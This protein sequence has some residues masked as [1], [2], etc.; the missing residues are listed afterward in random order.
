MAANCNVNIPIPNKKITSVLSADKLAQYSK[1]FS[2]L[3]GNTM[4]DLIEKNQG[5]RNITID[6]FTNNTV[7]DTIYSYTKDVLEAIL[8]ANENNYS[9][10]YME[11]LIIP[12]GYKN[13]TDKLEK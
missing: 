8:G 5:D 2:S 9:N 3:V 7:V 6:K 12:E 11:G 1:F 13:K 4:S 10:E